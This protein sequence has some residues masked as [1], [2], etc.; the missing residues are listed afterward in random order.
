[1]SLICQQLQRIREGKQ[2][3]KKFGPFRPLLFMISRNS[4][5]IIAAALLLIRPLLSYAAEQSA[6]WQHGHTHELAELQIS[7]GITRCN[8]SLLTE[9]QKKQTNTL[10]NDKKT[11]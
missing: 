8:P 7:C 11:D 2:T 5:G 10:L 4:A 1:M 6:L 3:F 9:K